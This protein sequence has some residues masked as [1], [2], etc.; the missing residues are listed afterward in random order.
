M[1][2]ILL[3]LV[4]LF[5]GWQIARAESPLIHPGRPTVYPGARLIRPLDFALVQ[6]IRPLVV[7]QAPSVYPG[8]RLITPLRNALVPSGT[9]GLF[10]E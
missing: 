6:T 2:T 9:A 8:D 3:L 4:P 5:I 7:K 1:K 10:E